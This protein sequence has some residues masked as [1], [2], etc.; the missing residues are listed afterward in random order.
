MDPGSFVIAHL[1]NPKEQFWGQLRELSSSGVTLRGISLSSFEDWA[2]QV[3]RGPEMT[4]DVV[5][6]FFPMHRVERVFLDEDMG[7]LPSLV[8]RFFTICGIHAHEYFETTFA[9]APRSH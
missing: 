6:M 2:R 7:V 9:P 8:R 1:I 4:M 5:L 3:A